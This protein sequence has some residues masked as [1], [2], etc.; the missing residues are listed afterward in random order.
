MWKWYVLVGIGCLNLATVSSCANSISERDRAQA[1]THYDL[2]VATLNIGDIRGALK[3]LLD[4]TKLDPELADVHNAL[5]L[6]YHR[7]DYLD[8]GLEH[9]NL[10]LKWR[11]DFSEAYNNRGVL[12]MDLGRYD[13]AIE[14]FKV[15]LED[16]LYRTPSSAEGNMGW[17]YYK[18][19]DAQQGVKHIKN[20]VA[21]NPKF[22]R[23]YE[24][25]M[26]IALHLDE[27]QGVESS[28]KKFDRYCMG[29]ESIAA[30]ILPD[31]I[32]QMKYYYGLSL[33]KQ[34][35]RTRAREIFEEC[36]LFDSDEQFGSKCSSAFRAL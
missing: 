27:E 21:I 3:E 32:R 2:G 19:G 8:K 24:W 11:P 6:V 1:Q 17:A 31:Y 4:A 5:G 7:L 35:D 33:L 23:G 10:A 26:R 34:G 9:Y 22:C 18:K 28:Y 14:S 13:E 25:L 30:V 29:D 15:A 16:I 12:L 36:A 20:A